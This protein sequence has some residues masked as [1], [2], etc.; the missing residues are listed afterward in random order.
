MT[1]N[2]K[3]VT[4]KYAIATF[5]LAKDQGDLNRMYDMFKVVL[6][7]WRK[8]NRKITILK[9]KVKELKRQLKTEVQR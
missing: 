4:I 2:R 3:G 1:A 6:E 7:L 5:S 9:T 8:R